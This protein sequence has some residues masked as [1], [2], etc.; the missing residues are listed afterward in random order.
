MKKLALATLAA[1]LAAARGGVATVEAPAPGPTT[2]ADEK[3]FSSD[4]ATLLEFEFDGE[5]LASSSWDAEGQV[6]AQLLY[7]VGHLNGNRAVARLD[8]ITVTNVRTEA[9]GGGKTKISYRAKLPVAWGSKTNLPTSYQLKLPR[10][11]SSAGQEAFASKY[12]HDCVDYGAHDV[13]AGS[14]FYYYRPNARSCRLD[15]GDV[16]ELR[17]TAT[18]SAENTSGKYPEY[19]KVWEDGR[20]EVVAIFG[21]YEDGATTDADAGIDAYDS[22]VASMKRELRSANLVTTPATIPASPGVGTPDVT[23]EGTLPGGKKVKVTALLVDNVRTAPAS[24]YERYEALST[25]ADVIFYNGHAGLGAN[26]RAL[27]SRG[28]FVAGKYL[29]LFMNGCDT[30]AY[31]DGS[32]AQSRA[33]LNPDDPTGTKYLEFVTNAMPAFF[34]NMSDSSMALIQALLKHDAPKTYS[35]IFSSISSSQ[36]VVVTGEEDNVYVPGYGQGGGGT[37]GAFAGMREQG[38]VDGGE[39]LRYETPAVAAGKYTVKLT[40][41]GDADLYVK[42]GAQPTTSSYDCRPY[43]SDSNETCEVTV[44]GTQKIHVSVFGYADS[45]EF[46]MT[47]EGAG[48]PPAGPQP[49]AGLDESGTVSKG[50]EK[51]FTAAELPAGSYVFAMTGSGDAD[52]YVKVGS[53]PTTSSYDCRPY[54]SSSNETCTVDVPAG[55]TVHVMVRG[56]ASSSDY[57]LVGRVK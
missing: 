16:V 15:A 27:A 13:D 30:F 53:A 11:V 33:R 26:V 25:S 48:A 57:R 49:W 44:T 6:E 9:A 50:Q 41:T 20:L 47:I 21:K 51:R 43:A 19:H 3:N 17:A 52:L 39:E 29:I 4:V 14:M 42:V 22:F 2:E 37:A 12:G 31:V 56:Y 34:S 40:G 46:T 24:F 8:K 55:A 23:F 7:T 28:R 1:H 45:S 38:Q 18:V 35:Q 32:L 36:V 10:D 54:D 5:L